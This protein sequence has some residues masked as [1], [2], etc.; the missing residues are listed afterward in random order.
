M[1]LHLIDKKHGLYG[2]SLA[3]V[4][5]IVIVILG[6]GSLIGI[7]YWRKRNP[8]ARTY[9]RG[10]VS[11]LDNALYNKENEEVDIDGTST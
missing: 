2:G 8:A 11:G 5:V 1:F 6:V 3:A 7:L 9:G 4:I 10:G